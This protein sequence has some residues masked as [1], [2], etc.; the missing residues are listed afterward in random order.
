ELIA[1][2]RWNSFS[3]VVVLE[4]AHVPAAL[5]GGGSRCAPTVVHQRGIEIDGHASTPLYLVGS[6]DLERLRFLDCDVTN[7]VHEI[8]PRG[9]IAIIGVGG[10][11]DGQ[12]ALLAGHAPIVGI[13]LNDR[14][15]EVLRGPLGA[16]TGI[17]DHPDVRLVVDEARSYLERHD[18]RFDVIQASLIDTWAATGAGAHALG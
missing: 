18:D 16:Q 12:A 5:W 6:S 13:E 1:L 15:I 2:E 7:A 14:V 10:S 9:S 8:R 17:A 11:R 4:S 3:R